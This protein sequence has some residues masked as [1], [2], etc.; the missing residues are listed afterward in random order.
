MRLR[1]R[2]TLIAAVVTMVAV[3]SLE[4]VPGLID[5][6]EHIFLTR[7]DQGR[8]Q[9]Q[10]LKESWQYRTIEATV[11]AK[12]DLAGFTSMRDLETEGAMY[13]D[14]DAPNAIHRGLIPGPRLEVRAREICDEGRSSHSQRLRPI[15]IVQRFCWAL[16]RSDSHSRLARVLPLR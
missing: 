2:F 4:M 14:V 13:S 16:L 6:R 9:E 1:T 12:R 10:L 15:A 3:A 7:E 8:Y 5:A 11:N